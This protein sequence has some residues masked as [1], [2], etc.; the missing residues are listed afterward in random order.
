M[1]GGVLKRQF[2]IAG[3]ILFAAV[4]MILGRFCME[5]KA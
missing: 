4:I 5:Y 3:I 1:V 2:F